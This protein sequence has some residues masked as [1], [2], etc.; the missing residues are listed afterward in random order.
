MTTNILAFASHEHSNLDPNISGMVDET[1]ALI[2]AGGGALKMLVALLPES[3]KNVENASYDLTD[4]FKKLAD[5]SNQQSDMVQA[6]LVNIG[7]IALED[8]QVSIEE[9]I[10]LFSKTLDDSISK[11]LFVAKKALAMVY[12]MDDAIRNLNE[13]TVFSRRIQDITK[14]SNL[15]A[16]NALIESARAGEAGKGF[17]VVANEVKLL[18]GEIASLSDHMRNRTDLI[19]KSVVEGF[20]VLKE[21]ATT[22]M[23]D[24]IMAKDTLEALMQGLVKQSEASIRVMQSSANSSRDISN[25]IQGMIV[26]LQFQD[27]NTQVIENAVD[28]IRC[29]LSMLDEI[30]KKAQPLAGADHAVGTKNAAEAILAVIKLGEIRQRYYDLLQQSGVTLSAKPTTSSA[31]AD[32]ELF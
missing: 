5:S 23:N 13:I 32:V 21:V 11:M 30:E 9:F 14:Q 26:D 4:R 27:R 10:G 25:S 28:V 1:L 18:S 16:L 29:C 19:M 24:N 3:A 31:F 17:A 2:N 6:L 15:L 8:R 7:S 20:S 22:D 12:N